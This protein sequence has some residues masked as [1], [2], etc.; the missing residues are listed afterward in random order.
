MVTNSPGIY[1]L[2]HLLFLW[3]GIDS[4]KER[5]IT[6]NHET[7][8]YQDL[9]VRLLFFWAQVADLFVLAGGK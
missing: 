5:V 7:I 4:W 3:I 6:F 2:G 8:R 9:P 1:C